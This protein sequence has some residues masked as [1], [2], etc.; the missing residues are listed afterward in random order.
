MGTAG[1]DLA[2]KVRSCPP[3]SS[4]PPGQTGI[5]RGRGLLISSSLR[6]PVGSPGHTLGGSAGAK[7]QLEGPSRQLAKS[8]RG[9]RDIRA[10]QKGNGE[11][12]VSERQDEQ[13]FPLPPYNFIIM[14]L[15][16]EP[17]K[18]LF[19]TTS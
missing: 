5:L 7:K 9:G 19:A 15:V 17:T 12:L 4:V 8:A 14:A 16:Q 1:S 18:I 11:T 3:V 13:Q 10:E 6:P 2:Q